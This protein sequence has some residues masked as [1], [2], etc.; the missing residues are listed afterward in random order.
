MYRDECSA[1]NPFRCYVGDVSARIGTIDIGYGRQ[2]LTDSNFPLDGAVS[3]IG[4]SIV[5]FGPERSTD[6]FAC[7]NIEPDHDIIKYVNIERPPR[8]VTYDFVDFFQYLLSF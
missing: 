6:I 1:D 2:M 3:S 5:I 7:A 8:F 4:R